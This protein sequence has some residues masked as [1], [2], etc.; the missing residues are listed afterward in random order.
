AGGLNVLGA[1][2]SSWA[3]IH[4]GYLETLWSSI[5]WVLIGTSFVLF[6]KNETF[7]SSKG[8]RTWSKI[9]EL[10]K[11]LTIIKEEPKVLLGGV[12]RVINTTAQFAFPVFLPIYMAEHGFTTKEWLQIWGGIFT[13]NIIFNLL[14]GFIG[15]FIG[16]RKT[17]MWFGG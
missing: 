6:L 7:P 5:F 3:I 16:W 12:I 11:G 17:I 10:S 9:R 1:Y 2:Y 15:D 14:F 8:K 13:S 4:L